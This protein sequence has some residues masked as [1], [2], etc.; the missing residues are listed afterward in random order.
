MVDK[1][2][3]PYKDVHI[4][5]PR[6]CEYVLLHGK[7]DFADVIQLKTLRWGNCPGLSLWAQCNHKGP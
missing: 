7:R 4:L 6:T 2:M 5:I 1:I 3:L